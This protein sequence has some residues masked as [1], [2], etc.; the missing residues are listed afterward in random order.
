MTCLHC[1]DVEIRIRTGQG[2]LSL[3]RKIPIQILGLFS[4]Q[5]NKRLASHKIQLRQE[6]CHA[7]YVKKNADKGIVLIP[8]PL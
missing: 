7:F 1:H 6:F 3:T 5:K 4:L 2:A 8:H